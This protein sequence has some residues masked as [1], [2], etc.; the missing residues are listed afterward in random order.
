MNIPNFASRCHAS[1]STM[2]LNARNERT[3]TSSA[4]APRLSRNSL[5]LCSIFG[6][7]RRQQ[8]PKLSIT[9]ERVVLPSIVGH[10]DKSASRQEI[11]DGRDARL[12]ILIRRTTDNFNG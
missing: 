9:G 4:A 5:L 7:L 12:S 1:R 3:W 10:P 6:S 11:K 8:L 2:L